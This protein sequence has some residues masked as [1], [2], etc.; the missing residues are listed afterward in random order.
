MNA[1]K[2]VCASPVSS[3]VFDSMKSFM[4]LKVN[5]L[6]LVVQCHSDGFSYLVETKI[7]KTKFFFSYKCTVEI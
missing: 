5:M 1:L 2:D 3:S 7:M 6:I 4:Y